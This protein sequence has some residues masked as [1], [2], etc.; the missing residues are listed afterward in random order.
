VRGWG[1]VAGER[2][3]INFSCGGGNSTAPE[4][5]DS[6]GRLFGEV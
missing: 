1:D 6:G 3:K 5:L 4:I 2:W